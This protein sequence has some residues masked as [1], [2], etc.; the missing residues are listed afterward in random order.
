LAGVKRPV[1]LVA[2][3]VIAGVAAVAGWRAWRETAPGRGPDHHVAVAAAADLRFALDD[4]RQQFERQRPDV[5]VEVTYGSSGT[6]YAQ[7][8]NG[9]PFDMF[10]SADEAYPRRLADQGL[11]MSGGEFTYG[12]GRL[13]LWVPAGSSVDVEHAGF[14]A[15]DDGRVAHVAIANPD[16]APY[17]R[18]AIVALEG[19]GRLNRVKPKLVY[20]ENIAQ[21]LQ[22]VQSGAADA[23]IV[24]LSLTLAPTVSETGRSWPV[25]LD[26]YPLMAQGGTIMKRAADP[27]AAQDLRAFL[28]SAAGQATLKRYG[29]FLPE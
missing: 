15:L 7:L 2:L 27:A 20:G 5:D 25:P 9:A 6:F 29:F 11:T 26:L 14:D 24:A 16:H 8:V 13:V 19:A 10:L 22:F 12:V 3:V 1:A 4:L 17:G 23:G 28:L 21:T 18:A